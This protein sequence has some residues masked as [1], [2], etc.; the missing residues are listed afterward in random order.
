MNR[1]NRIALCLTIFL[2]NVNLPVYTAQA[3]AQAAGRTATRVAPR[4]KWTKR[5]IGAGGAYYLWNDQQTELQD[6]RSRLAHVDTNVVKSQSSSIAGHETTHRALNTA[7]PSWEKIS[8]YDGTFLPARYRFW[9]WAQPKLQTLA[10]PESVQNMLKINDTSESVFSLYVKYYLQNL[11]KNKENVTPVS[12]T[13]SRA[14]G[15]QQEPIAPTG[16][17][18]GSKSGKDTSSKATQPKA[19]VTP[20]WTN[21]W[22]F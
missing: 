4:F 17:G 5:G 7:S 15:K 12:S 18:V 2:A 20:N 22:D 21:S 8:P 3:A 6:L 11:L 1:L 10:K 9:Q 19:D 14:A 16:K 13:S